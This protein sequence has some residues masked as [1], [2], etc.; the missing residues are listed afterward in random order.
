MKSALLKDKTAIV[1]GGSSGIGRGISLELAKHGSDVIIAD[2]R[3]DP[4]MGGEPTHK[5]IENKTE[6]NSEFVKCDVSKTSDIEN[7]IEKTEDHGHEKIDILV[8]NAAILKEDDYDISEQEFETYYNINVKGYFF[9]SKLTAEKMDEGSIINIASVESLE[10]LGLR[11]V[12]GSTRGT[13]RQMTLA[14][15]D[16]LAPKIRV[17]MIHPGLIDTAM[18]RKDTDIFEDENVLQDFI[19]RVPLERYGK[20]EDIGGPTVFLASDLSKYI[21]ASEIVVDGGMTYTF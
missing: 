8:N 2:I 7:L 20:P 5:K 9:T 14:L 12:Y 21:T 4:R 13:I 16:R 15:A 10:G 17:N 18:A 1:T 19:N 3:K 11:P 6:N